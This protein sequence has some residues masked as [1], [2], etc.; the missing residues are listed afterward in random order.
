MKVHDKTPHI[1]NTCSNIFF[2]KTTVHLT[3]WN[4]G[5]IQKV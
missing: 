1:G 2:K 3:Y 5:A 4:L